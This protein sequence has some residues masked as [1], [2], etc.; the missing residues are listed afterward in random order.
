MREEEEVMGGG[1][2]N[3]VPYLCKGKKGMRKGVGQ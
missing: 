1:R 3:A 2:K